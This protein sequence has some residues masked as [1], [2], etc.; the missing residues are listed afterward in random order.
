MI[1]L[2]HGTLDKGK[3]LATFEVSAV[4]GT[5]PEFP[6]YE[7]T[8]RGK[9]WKHLSSVK[10]TQNGWGLKWNPQIYELPRKLGNLEAGTLLMA[11]LS[12]SPN[13]VTTHMKVELYKSNDR[14]RTWSYLSTMYSQPW[15]NGIDDGK[16]HNYWEPFLMMD[17]KNQLICYISDETDLN[18]SQLI[19]H[20]TSN[21]G[22]NWSEKKY[23]VAPSDKNLRPGM[24]I[25]AKMG[26]GKYI[27][28]YEM[29][30]LGGAPAYFKISDRPTD[31]SPASDYGNP[32]VSVDGIR[33]TGAPYVTWTPAG[34]P[35]GM[36]IVSTQY[37]EGKNDDVG[38]DYFVN[39]NYGEG[40]GIEC[41][42][43]SCTTR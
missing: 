16:G 10:D 13:Y 1:E 42:L 24:P 20:I 12:I 15:N 36:V 22:V 18:H 4:P 19:Q 35:N 37:V 29:V 30:N 17:E 33:A 38:G 27:M 14:G 39:Y 43:Q 41:H 34:G 23:D 28:T 31:W 2:Q 7:S 25:V 11:G 9:T 21:D 32:I 8:D 40:N 6:I 3:L 5:P 26:N